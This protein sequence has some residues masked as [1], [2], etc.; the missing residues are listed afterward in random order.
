[1]G[2]IEDPVY[3]EACR[4]AC[5]NLQDNVHVEWLKERSSAEVEKVLESN[6]FFISATLGENF[7]HAIF[8]ALSAGKPV[9]ISDRTQWK[10]LSNQCAGF[11]IPLENEDEWRRTVQVCVDMN[12]DKYEKWSLSAAAYSELFRKNSELIQKNLNLF[13]AK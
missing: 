1:M 13:G 10:N 5:R 2:P 4:K 7:G 8:E 9:I 12:H 3:F 6:H 11:D